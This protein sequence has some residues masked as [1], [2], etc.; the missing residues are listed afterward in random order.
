MV[1]TSINKMIL[2]I[3]MII[4]VINKMIMVLKV[5][6]MVKMIIMVIKM[7]IMVMNKM[8]INQRVKGVIMG[9]V[10]AARSIESHLPSL[11]FYP[12]IMN[13]MIKMMI[14]IISMIIDYHQH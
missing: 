7:M 13:I 12:L 9:K 3:K 11:S 14:I 2:V 5:I 8:I 10:V 1:L 6:M 4:M